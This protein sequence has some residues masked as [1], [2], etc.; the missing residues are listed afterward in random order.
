MVHITPIARCIR[1]LILDDKDTE[2]VRILLQKQ[3]P[4]QELSSKLETWLPGSSQLDR[5]NLSI[6]THVCL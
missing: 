6:N 4:E 5:L 3:S 2:E 1:L